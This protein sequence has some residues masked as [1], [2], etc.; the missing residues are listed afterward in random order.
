MGPL[1]GDIERPAAADV[2]AVMVPLEG[3]TV[4]VDPPDD[5]VAAENLEDGADDIVDDV[6]SRPSGCRALIVVSDVSR[7]CA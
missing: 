3:I 4:A 6:D 1:V 2:D 5:P 7:S